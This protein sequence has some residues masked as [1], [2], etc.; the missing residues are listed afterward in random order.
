M[1][2]TLTRRAVLFLPGVWFIA[3]VVFIVMRVLPGDPAAT[4]VGEN[5]TSEAIDAMRVRLGLDRPLWEQYARFLFDI[6]RG[7]LGSSLVSSQPVM[8]IIAS[9][10]PHTVI[11]ALSAAAIG[12]AVGLPI[13]LVAAVRRDSAF[14][15]GV[16]LVA[17]LL[18]SV[19]VFYSG[20]LLLIV[21]SLGLGWFPMVSSGSAPS[22]WEYLRQLALPA[23]SLGLGMAA[24]VM[25][26]T[27]GTAVEVLSE[28]YIR[29][30]RAK[31]LRPRVVLY[32]HALRNALIPIVTVVALYLSILIGGA[33]LTESVF[34]RPGVGKVLLG[35]I[36]NRDYIVVQST[37]VMYAVFVMLINLLVDVLYATLDPVIRTS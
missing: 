31:G 26:V 9:V 17:A 4:I 35:A 18:Y 36:Q 22:L 3:T 15:V 34:N 20:V 28:D 30:A 10:L 33:V 8:T 12:V 24:Y 32:R 37:L 13:G 29:T 1:R 5:A 6:A 27:R 19:P 16:R 14:D 23:L 25:R 7:D 2:G 21:F 11:L